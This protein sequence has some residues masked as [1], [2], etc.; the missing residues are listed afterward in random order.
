MFHCHITFH[1]DEGMMGQFVVTPPSNTPPSV[2]IS[3][4]I[5]KEGNSGN[6]QMNFTVALSSPYTQTVTVNYKTKDQTAV[7][8]SDYTAANG[9]LTFNAGETIKTISVGITGDVLQEADET[10]KVTLSNSV[11]ATIATAAGKGKI[12]NDDTSAIAAGTTE[13]DI[14][15]NNG[16]KIFPNPV[17]NGILNIA[18]NPVYTKPLQLMLFD[19]AGNIAA[20][21]TIAANSTVYKADVSNIKSGVY[22]LLLSNNGAPVYKQKV[23]VL[24]SR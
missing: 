22:F 10:F 8:P 14:K 6:T 24:N 5:I 21:K 11:N 7:A 18:I 13:N 1:E 20:A 17:T 12:T 9:T 23:Q 4:S 19:A 3:N 15:I 16:I 2:S